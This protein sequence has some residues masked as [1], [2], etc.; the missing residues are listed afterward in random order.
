MPNNSSTENTRYLSWYASWDSFQNVVNLLFP[1]FL[2]NS[3]KDFSW[4]FSRHSFIESTRDF[5]RVFFFIPSL[6]LPQFSL[7]ISL[8]IPWNSFQI[9]SWLVLLIHPLGFLQIFLTLFLIM[10]FLPKLF[11]CIPPVNF[12]GIPSG[13]LLLNHLYITWRIFFRDSFTDFSCIS[14]DF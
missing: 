13:I 10:R 9:F 4:D 14:P 1:W 3:F 2:Q 12:F 8:K 6:I 5:F 7:K 11:Q